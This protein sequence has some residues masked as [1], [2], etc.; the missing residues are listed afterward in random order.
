MI[1]GYKVE[2]IFNY[3]LILHFKNGFPEQMKCGLNAILTLKKY[4]DSK[5]RH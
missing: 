2:Q 5:L 3:Y 4:Q 1:R